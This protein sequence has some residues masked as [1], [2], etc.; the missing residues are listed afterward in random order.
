MP[1]I[2][3]HITL[4]LPRIPRLAPPEL[5]FQACVYPLHRCAFSITHILG[6]IEIQQLL[7]LGFGLQLDLH[8]S[9]RG[10]ISMIGTRP[11]ARNCS[12]IKFA[13]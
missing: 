2:R 9:Q 12:G 11:G 4:V 7:P 6:I 13:S 3:W 10:L 1:N 5:I 8:A